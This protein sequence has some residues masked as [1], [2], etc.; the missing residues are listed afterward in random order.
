MSPWFWSVIT[1]RFLHTR[2]DFTALLCMP[3]SSSTCSAFGEIICF[4][5]STW[6][7]GSQCWASQEPEWS[8]DRGATDDCVLR[9][10]IFSKKIIYVY[11][12]TYIYISYLYVCR[13]YRCLWSLCAYR[14]TW[15]NGSWFSFL[16]R[17]IGQ[18]LKAPF[19]QRGPSSTRRC[20]HERFWTSLC[21]TTSS[22]LWRRAFCMENVSTL[23][24]LAWPLLWFF[25]HCSWIFF[26]PPGFDDRSHGW[27][28]INCRLW[29]CLGSIGRG[30]RSLGPSSLTVNRQHPGE[31]WSSVKVMKNIW[32]YTMLLNSANFP[33]HIFCCVA[34]HF[35]SEC[36]DMI[37]RI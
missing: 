13:C 23:T 36:L 6:C 35:R 8:I 22:V 25:D 29:P 28:Q 15:N 14:A 9:I 3:W 2:L 11:T 32:E 1:F 20:R 12:Y 7:Q 17:L 21:S 30:W 5:F 10:H 18:G 24:A 26:T 19:S 27:V 33:L 16:T 31:E 34:L 37:L 4:T